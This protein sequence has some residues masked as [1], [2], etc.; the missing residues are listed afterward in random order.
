MTQENGHL[1][2]FAALVGFLSLSDQ[3]DNKFM[4]ELGC[5]CFTSYNCRDH[6]LQN[7][8]LRE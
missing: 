2:H 7:E 5:C 4:K 3:A 8:S 1:L 6:R